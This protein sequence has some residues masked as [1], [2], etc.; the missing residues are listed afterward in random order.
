MRSFK[1]NILYL[2][3]HINP[4]GITSYILSLAKGLKAKGHNVYIATSAGQLLSKFI[5]EGII[6]MPIP[7]KTKSEI[8][9]K[10]LISFF[11]LIQSVKEKGIDVIHSNTRVTQV[12]GCLLSR[13]S[14]KPY[15]STCHGFF[16]RRFSRR[17][18]PCWGDKVIAISQQVKEHLINDFKVR[19]DRVRLIAN[20]VDINEFRQTTV[21]RL[22]A[23]LNLGLGNG[24][25]IGIVAR[26]SDVKG[27]IYLIEAMETIVKK[28]PDAQLLIV[29]EGKI[30]KD[31]I[32]LCNRL[33]LGKN[34]FFIPS[35]MD[36][37]K[38]LSAMDLFVL[39]SL[40]EGLGLS[41]MEAMASGLAVIG[42]DVGG[43]KSLILH[44]YTGLLVKPADSRELACAISEL[45]LDQDRANIMGNNARMFIARDFS[46]EKMVLETERL[47]LECVNPALSYSR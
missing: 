28:V 26:L 16:K 14:H 23:K 34:I 35:V 6:Y 7:I 12:L 37:S 39:P 5:Y 2:T 27:H 15:V 43:I 8:S 3:N 45:L 10:V 11:R 1:M 42:S 38:V 41:L 17:V 31:L 25:V 18:F 13:Y 21:K 44:G 46:Q 47:Y 36:T 9:P 20:G 32:N 29:G 4:G 19:E 40:E 24:P 33:K 22:K 30:E